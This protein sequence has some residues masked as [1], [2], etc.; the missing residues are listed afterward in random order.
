MAL[1]LRAVLYRPCF[2]SP[3]C[4]SHLSF[5]LFAWCRMVCSER[6]DGFDGVSVCDGRLDSVVDWELMVAAL[7]F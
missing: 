6:M 2:V 4:G 7:E 1:G 5:L 3:L